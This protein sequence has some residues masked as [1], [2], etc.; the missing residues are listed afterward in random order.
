M[1]ISS[2]ATTCAGLLLA[3]VIL[4]ADAP[5]HAD[6]VECDMATTAAGVTVGVGGT[7]T[8]I[9]AVSSIADSVRTEP[10]SGWRLAL[11]L[12]SIGNA[13]GMTAGLIQ[14]HLIAASNAWGSSWCTEEQEFGNAAF[15]P[16]AISG[17]V[18]VAL[19]L[20]L[21]TYHVATYARDRMQ[22]AV[23]PIVFRTAQGTTSPGLG[24]FGTF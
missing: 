3:A 19:G 7:V 5:A 22:V 8:L 2:I 24:I 16:L 1:K 10:V 9:V 12:M 4:I 23:T 14:A 17:W 13:L 15:R 21:G 11:G 20:G 18:L 6:T